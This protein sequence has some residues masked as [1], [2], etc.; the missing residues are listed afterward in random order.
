MKNWF[1]SPYWYIKFFLIFF[2][3]TLHA[4]QWQSIGPEGAMIL[5]VKQDVEN[6]NIYYAVVYGNPVKIY[7]STNNCTSWNEYSTVGDLS[8]AISAYEKEYCCFIIDE[9]NP[10]IFYVT[11]FYQIY[12]STNY[13]LT[14]TK[15][16][17]DPNIYSFQIDSNNAEIFYAIGGTYISG[18]YRY[19]FFKSTNSGSSYTYYVLPDKAYP[20]FSIAVDRQNRNNIY[21]AGNVSKNTLLKSTDGGLTF[22]ELQIPN[23]S[24]AGTIR[25][26]AIDPNN[27]EVLYL[28]FSGGIY[29]GTSAGQNWQKI[30][31]LPPSGFH[32]FQLDHSNKIIYANY[33]NAIWKLEEDSAWSHFVINNQI[34]INDIAFDKGST[35]KLI[36]ATDYGVYSTTSSGWFWSSCNSNL[37]AGTVSTI[38]LD[39]VQPST[40][41][42]GLDY[43]SG[44]YKTTKALDNVSGKLVVDWNRLPTFYNATKIQNFIISLVNQDIVLALDANSGLYKSSDGGYNWKL[45]NNGYNNRLY[46]GNCLVRLNEGTF[47]Q[48]GTYWDLS[49]QLGRMAFLKSSDNCD[50]WNLKYLSTEAGSIVTFIQDET[51]N[52]ILYAGGYFNKPNANSNQYS[53]IYKSTDDGNN[54]SII[55]NSVFGKTDG[56]TITQ[57]LIDPFNNEKI[58]AATN[59][60]LYISFNGGADWVAPSIIRDIKSIIA[61]PNQNGLLFLAGNSGVFKSTDS[62]LNWAKMIEG[63]PGIDIKTL[64]YDCNKKILYA[65][66]SNRGIW[67]YDL[68]PVGIV[69]NELL[70]AKF[71]L[72]QNY[73]NPFNP[74][75]TISY[76]L[77]EAGM[78]TLNIY[79]MLGQKVACLVNEVKTAGMHKATFNANKL[80]SGIYIYELRANNKVL[81]NKMNLIK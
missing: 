5:A 26:L 76:S 10:N 75:T 20:P 6:S 78:V 45:I 30:N 24:E 36:C 15:M 37:I 11:H 58:Y 4:Q 38:K 54:W 49:S 48:V 29:R 19:M 8:S 80:A 72:E 65:S 12:K 42:I 68:R 62:G 35:A 79:N 55:G 44:I 1:F 39:P 13:G 21:L 46:K 59:R 69:N 56:E 70:P 60:G 34:S 73:P 22:N 3:L 81:K 31:E 2:Q 7:R 25:N 43:E 63:L 66:I 51:N 27:S 28:G 33:T 57:L 17:L 23:V 16:N 61:D 64:A 18:S 77:P 67:R 14:W 9:K 50:T 32:K 41:Y 40:L 47:Y 74:T 52:H 71:A 53:R